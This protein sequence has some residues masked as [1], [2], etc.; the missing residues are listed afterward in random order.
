MLRLLKFKD[1]TYAW[2]TKEG[3]SATPISE[4]EA[5]AQGHWNHKIDVMQINTAIKT[6]RMKGDEFAVF[7]EGN[8]IFLYTD[9]NNNVVGIA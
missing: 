8:R 3:V 1:K 6:L 9:K 2:I 7:G 4:S 5:I